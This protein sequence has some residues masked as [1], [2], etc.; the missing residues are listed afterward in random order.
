MLQ[1]YL[2]DVCY[3]WW[4]IVMFGDGLLCLVVVLLYLIQ[5]VNVIVGIGL[6]AQQD[7]SSSSVVD[8]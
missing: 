2:F 3:V 7:D 1:Y 5:I 6:V 4:W 8:Q